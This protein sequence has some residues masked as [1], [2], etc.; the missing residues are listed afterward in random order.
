MKK[1]AESILKYGE[2]TT[3]TQNLWY[4]KTDVI[5]INNRGNWKRLG[6]IH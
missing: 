6:I 4:V 2:V 3:E 5:T 1:E